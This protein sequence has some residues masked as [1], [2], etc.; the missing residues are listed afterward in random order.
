MNWA[1]RFLGVGNAQA[2]TLGSASAVIEHDD[3]PLLMI[4]C[5]PQ[6][7]TAYNERY[8]AP[9]QAIFLTHA[10]L[11]HIGGMERLFFQLYF[12][13]ARRGRT[14][15]YVPARIVPILQERLANYPDVLAE[16]GANF[17][18]AFQLIPVARGFWH[19]SWYF[20]V[21]EVR[22]HVAGSAYGLGL[23]GAMVYSGD[24]RPIPELLRSYGRG[25]ELIAHDCALHGNPSHTGLAD[26]EREYPPAMRA[27]MI[28]YHYGSV[29]EAQALRAAGLRVAEPGVAVP[30]SE[31]E[32]RGPTL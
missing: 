5:G 29:A 13:T 23:R 21:F 31:P 17:W 18:D 22:H 12:D 2:V 3:Q 14:R 25:D 9:P 15:V 1:L 28:V 8:G 16:G 19:A 4:D 20:D 27:R 11:D 7:L 30:L 32:T 24:T 6:A 26:L 10:H